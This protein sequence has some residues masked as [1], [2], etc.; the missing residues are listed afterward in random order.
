MAKDDIHSY[1]KTLG[2]IGAILIAVGVAREQI[3][4]TQE[5]VKVCEADIKVLDQD[6]HDLQLEQGK[7]VNISE[8]TLAVLTGIQTSLEGIKDS[9]NAQNT[10]I[11]LIQ[12]DISNL[13][14]VE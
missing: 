9:S 8:N 2:V 1:I 13:E 7:L 6:V 4:S 10:A 5:D 3:T 11:A 14:L 12:K